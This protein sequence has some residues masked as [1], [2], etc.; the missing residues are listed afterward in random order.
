MNS[1]IFPPVLLNAAVEA[2]ATAA[3]TGL[4][5]I[6]AKLFLICCRYSTWFNEYQATVQSKLNM[7]NMEMKAI[8]E[9]IKLLEENL[10]DA[11]E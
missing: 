2:A 3:G 8:E 4:L 1:I 9:R 11:T 7:L 5:V 6:S 10:S